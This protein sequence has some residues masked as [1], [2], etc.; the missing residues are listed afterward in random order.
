M[1]ELIRRHTNMNKKEAK[2]RVLEL[3]T[4]VGI[5][6]PEKAMNSYPHELSGGMRQ[7]VMIAM[8]MSSDPKVLIADEPTTAWMLRSRRRSFICFWNFRKKTI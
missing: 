2:A 7:R 1:V 3:L 6:D 5:T 4:A 8:A